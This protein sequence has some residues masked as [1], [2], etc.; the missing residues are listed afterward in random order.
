MA[1]VL[2]VPLR[3]FVVSGQAAL[4]ATNGF[5]TMELAHPVT[6]KVDL[7]V[8]DHNPLYRALGLSFATARMVEF[9]R[10]D[11]GGYA[12]TLVPLG[13][14]ALGLP[15][16]LESGSPIRWELIGLVA[17]YLL[18]LFFGETQIGTRTIP[19]QQAGLLG[20]TPAATWI[21][22]SFIVLHFVM[23]MVF[24]PNV[25]GYRQ[26]L[27]MYLFLAIF[28]GRALVQVALVVWSLLESSALLNQRDST[29]RG[30][31]ERY[32]RDARKPSGH[33]KLA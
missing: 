28:A 9:V 30:D 11:P 5:A 15:Q 22:H 8:I 2:L 25:Y 23:M 20:G 24:L 6:S 14:Y 13:L 26:V 1:V 33:E 32:V 4:V 19:G 12:A 18:Y 21:L 16:L 27:P 7:R 31:V 3:N 10:Q 29:E 17:L